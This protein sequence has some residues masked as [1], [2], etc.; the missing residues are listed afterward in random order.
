MGSPDSHPSQAE[1]PQPSL[2]TDAA[3]DLLPARP[4]LAPSSWGLGEKLPPPPARQEAAKGESGQER[5]RGPRR[6]A[7]R[8]A[9]RSRS[10]FSEARGAGGRDD[11]WPPTQ[12]P[13]RVPM[14]LESIAARNP[15]A[16]HVSG[17]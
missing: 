4:D 13:P 10:L 3:A 15:Y 9:P 5:P 14:A 17:F 6:G 7:S 8:A 1:A 11:D 12:G 16:L 2:G